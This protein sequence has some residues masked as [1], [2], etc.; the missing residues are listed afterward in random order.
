MKATLLDTGRTGLRGAW[1]WLLGPKRE[2]FRVAGMDPLKGWNSRGRIL[3][4]D[5]DAVIRQTTAWVLR[6]AGYEATTAVDC[7]D[8][9]ETVGRIE[10]H[11]ILIDLSY[12]PD[13]ASGGMVAW[14]GFQ[15]M[16]WLRGLEGARHSKFIIFSSN[17]SLQHRVKALASGAVGFLPKPLEAKRLLDLVEHARGGLTARNG[18]HSSG[19]GSDRAGLRTDFSI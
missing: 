2:T 16:H 19:T 6:S 14:D 5:D 7:A 17:D 10:P 15:L 9:I 12:P 4:V 13:V 1:E 11:V 18:N 8:A 3:V